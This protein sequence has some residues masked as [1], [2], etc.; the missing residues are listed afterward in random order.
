MDAFGQ[1]VELPKFIHIGIDRFGKSQDV[2]A[3]ISVGNKR[4][5]IAQI[6]ISGLNERQSECRLAG[7]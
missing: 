6:S 2:R 5:V 4:F 7:P 1:V 3:S